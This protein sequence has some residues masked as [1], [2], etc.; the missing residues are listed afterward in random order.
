MLNVSGAF[1]PPVAWGPSVI[2]T[3]ITG[4]PPKLQFILKNSEVIQIA[5]RTKNMQL[6]SKTY[7]QVPE[8]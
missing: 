1:H 4:G 8:K 7:K 3:R 2:L 6:Y 5:K